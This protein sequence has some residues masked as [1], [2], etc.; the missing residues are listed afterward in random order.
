MK[1][2]HMV[3]VT[4]L[5]AGWNVF[6][7]A[8]LEVSPVWLSWTHSCAILVLSLTMIDRVQLVVCRSQVRPTKPTALPLG[9]AS[10]ADICRCSPYPRWL[11][12]TSRWRVAT[13]AARW[14]CRF[15]EQGTAHLP[16]GQ[17]RE[18]MMVYPCWAPVAQAAW[19]S[20]VVTTSPRC[21]S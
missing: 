21:L 15:H 17:H 10:C 7:L 13:P 2:Q 9:A 11:R 12:H 14:S 1:L 3:E 5:G 4:C 6:L 20:V 8:S 16:L 18:C 19:P